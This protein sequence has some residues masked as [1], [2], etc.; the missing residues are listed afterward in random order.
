VKLALAEPP[1]LAPLADLD[2]TSIH[3]GSSR[4]EKGRRKIGQCRL[5]KGRADL[6]RTKPKIA[7]GGGEGVATMVVASKKG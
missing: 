3:A 7:T 2:L 5:R 6:R 4:K 1:P